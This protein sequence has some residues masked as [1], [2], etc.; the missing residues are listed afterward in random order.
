MAEDRGDSE[1]R[2]VDMRIQWVDWTDSRVILDCGGVWDRKLEAFTEAGESA[3]IVTLQPGQYEAGD[4]FAG[5]LYYYVTGEEKPPEFH[6]KW[7]LFFIGGRRGG[8]SDLGVKAALAFAVATPA[9]EVVLVSPTE[10]QTE[11]LRNVLEANMPNHWFHWSESKMTFT[12]ANLT[13]IKLV[14]GY[15]P[16]I[17]KGLGRIDLWLLNEGQE[18]QKATYVKLRAPLADTG[19]IGIVAANPPDRPIGRWIMDQYDAA[20]AGKKTARLFEFDPRKNPTIDFDALEDMREDVGDK[21]YRRDVLGEMIE[22]GDLVWYAFSGVGS[23]CNVREMPEIPADEFNRQWLKK[24]LRREFDVAIGIDLQKTPSNVGA[25]AKFW[26]DP[27]DP[28]DAVIHYVDEIFQEGDEDDFIDVLERRGY[29]PARTALILD[30]SA[31]WQNNERTKGRGSEDMFRKRGWR[32]VYRPDRVAKA[33]PHISE[34]ML[35]TNGRLKNANGRRRAFF[36]PSCVGLI[37]AMRRYEN[38]NGTPNRHSDYAHASDAVSYL[39]WRIWPRILRHS[40]L[41]IKRGKR[42]RSRMER[43]FDRI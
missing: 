35:A 42:K 33:N 20:K 13:K 43:D 31:W 34:R 9:R 2:F 3:Q 8:K 4:Y 21:D 18:M 6:R 14:S 29:D 25:V 23:T 15:K 10:T 39:I 22:I 11:E 5:W 30:A 37:K 28:T 41:G 40:S 36:D 12:L 38:T 16:S 17:I 32:H 1:E 26:P 19:G 7:T 24:H 27:A